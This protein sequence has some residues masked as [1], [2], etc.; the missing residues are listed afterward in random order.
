MMEKLVEFLDKRM[1][2][3]AK[4]YDVI[5]YQGGRE[6]FRHYNGFADYEKKIPVRGDEL[7][8]LYSCSKPIT[9]VAAMQLYERG[10]FD[11]D[12]RLCDYM[13]E[14]ATMTVEGGA[15]RRLANHPILIRHLFEM[16]AG[17]DYNE[18]C[19]EFKQCL[20]QTDGRAPTR[21]IARKMALRPLGFEPGARWRYSLCHDL[22]AALVEV[23][24]GERFS[25]YVEKNIFR[26]LG[27]ARSTYRLTDEVKREV[28]PLYIYDAERKKPV[29]EARGNRLVIGT[30]YESG[31]AGCVST[32]EDYIRFLEGVRTYRLLKKETVELM[33]TD[34]LSP[35]G[36]DDTGYWKRQT[37]GYGLGVRCSK[38]V[39]GYGD[40]GW[41]GAAGAFMAID[42]ENEITVFYAQHLL[43]DPNN[44]NRHEVYD[45]V[46]DAL[47][48]K[49]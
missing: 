28:A 44:P 36:I 24:S 7:Y 48:K 6:I 35:L 10:L 40:F 4:G 38:G 15:E 23:I 11:L 2:N 34:R 37:H 41:D 47:V 17:F 30:E 25:D 21:E 13:P 31:G 8:Y 27:M 45:Y 19:E 18:A 26:P 32:V 39:Q 14:F 16:S 43:A 22:L 3:G 33:R 46:R 29:L 5:V 49:G 9:C 42:I 1:E 12:D 20:A